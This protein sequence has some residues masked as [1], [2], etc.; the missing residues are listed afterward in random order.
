MK[1]IILN[2]TVAPKNNLTARFIAIGIIAIILIVSAMTLGGYYV[3]P[4]YANR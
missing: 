3:A 2:D 4:Y 1:D